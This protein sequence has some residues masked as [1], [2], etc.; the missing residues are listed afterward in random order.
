MAETGFRLQI[1]SQTEQ[2]L[3]DQRGY[4]LLHSVRTGDGVQSQLRRI[5]QGEQL[6]Q[7][8][9]GVGRLRF[10]LIGLE[11]VAVSREGLLLPAAG[12]QQ[13]RKKQEAYGFQ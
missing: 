11:Q 9:P 3:A 12:Q 5:R 2:S 1:G 7:D 10:L 4:H 13:D 6:R 8:Q